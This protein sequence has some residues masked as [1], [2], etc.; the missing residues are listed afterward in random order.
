MTVAAAH[1]L[2]VAAFQQRTKDHQETQKKT[3]RLHRV[4]VNK[5]K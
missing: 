1:A 4:Q 2:P 3:R 5:V